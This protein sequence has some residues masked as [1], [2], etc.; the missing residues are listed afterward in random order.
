[1]QILQLVFPTYEHYFK[2]AI[3]LPFS[4]Y[5]AVLFTYVFIK[6]SILLWHQIWVAQSMTRWPY[7]LGLWQRGA[8]WLTHVADNTLISS[9]WNKAEE[10]RRPEDTLWLLREQQN[11]LKT[12]HEVLLWEFPLPSHSGSEV[13]STKCFGKHSDCT[14]WPGQIYSDLNIM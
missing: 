5:L 10:E 4:L 12:S 1:M 13:L 2:N 9:L 6:G 3:I 14:L 11:D 7:A 8:W